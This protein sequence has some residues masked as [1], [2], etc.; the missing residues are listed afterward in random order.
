MKTKAIYALSA[1]PVHFGHI[2]IIK[3]AA[4]DFDLTVL[5]AN[6][7]SKKYL[8]SLDERVTLIQQTVGRLVG[9][10]RVIALEDAS[11][12]TADFAYELNIPVIIRGVRSFS[13]YDMESMMRDI[14]ISQ[15]NGIETYFLKSDQKYCHVSSTAAKELFDHA[16]LIHEYVPLWVKEAMEKK[17][18]ITLIGITGNIASGKSWVCNGLNQLDPNIHNVDL[19]QLAHFILFKSDL[20]L[21]AYLREQI[22]NQFGFKSPKTFIS[23]CITPEERKQLGDIVFADAGKREK[24]NVIMHQPVITALRRAIHGKKGIVLVNSAL[25]A[26]FQMTHICNNN[27]ILVTTD[28]NTRYKRLTKRGLDHQQIKHRLESQFTDERKKYHI[29]QAIKRDAYGKLIV[30]DNSENKLEITKKLLNMLKSDF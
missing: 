13:D 19:D 18:G 6:N 2:D 16:G 15:Q 17:S 11:M 5:V 9:G 7:P 20:P 12:L 29:E 27:V 22:R 14:N 28:T 26:E 25:L 24:L 3:R 21:H 30:W 23:D 10:V 8:F 1:D 4:R